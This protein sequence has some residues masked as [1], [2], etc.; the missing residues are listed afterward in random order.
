MHVIRVQ[1]SRAA[2]EIKYIME[3]TRE[4]TILR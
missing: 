4:V 1:L 3:C 2:Y